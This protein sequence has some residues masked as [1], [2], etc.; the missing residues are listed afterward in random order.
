MGL[1]PYHQAG[2]EPLV[3]HHFFILDRYDSGPMLQNTGMIVL[4]QAYAM[5]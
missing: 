3:V 1:M 5:D 4:Q 2:L